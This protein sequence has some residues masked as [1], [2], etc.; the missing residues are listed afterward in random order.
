MTNELLEVEVSCAIFT[1]IITVSVATVTGSGD[2]WE[3]YA[4]IHTSSRKGAGYREGWG[5]HG[6]EQNPIER[7]RT[8]DTVS[9]LLILWNHPDV[10]GFGNLRWRTHE[11]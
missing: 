5:S 2:G 3:A 6:G 7:S 4:I 8:A 11:M 9:Y 10:T 1:H